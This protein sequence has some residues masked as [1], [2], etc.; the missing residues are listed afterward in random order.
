MPRRTF[1]NLEYLSK[2]FPHDNVKGISVRL[3]MEKKTR[4]AF[5]QINGVQTLAKIPPRSAQIIPTSFATLGARPS[6]ACVKD[7]QHKINITIFDKP[8]NYIRLET[9]NRI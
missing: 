1:S 8:G 6:A 9:E 7:S 2:V 3:S 5:P 4:S